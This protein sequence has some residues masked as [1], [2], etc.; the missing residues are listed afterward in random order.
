[1]TRFNVVSRRRKKKYKSTG[2]EKCA[3]VAGGRR[4]SIPFGDK[5]PV[6]SAVEG[7]RRAS[8]LRE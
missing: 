8:L 1:M 4:L 7:R 2:Q 6:F 3:K 5:R